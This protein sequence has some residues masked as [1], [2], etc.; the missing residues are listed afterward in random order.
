[1]GSL[2]PA[3]VEAEW[4]DASRNVWESLP[5]YPFGMGLTKNTATK[6]LA[7]W[8]FRKLIKA[9]SI[10][11]HNPVVHKKGHFFIFGGYGAESVIAMLDVAS[12]TWSKIGSLN[13]GRSAHAVV[14]RSN[15]FVIVG[16]R[17]TKS[18]ERCEMQN[19]QMVCVSTEPELTNFAY[20]PEAM[21]VDEN[22]CAN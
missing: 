13:Q 21:I 3:N 6:N 20:Y 8:R 4:L 9:N 22:F 16:G 18:T 7:E 10:F 1:M 14:V 17:D 19:N 11:S 15:D 12:K 2:N 5:D